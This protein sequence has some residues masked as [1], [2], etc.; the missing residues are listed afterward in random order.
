M[1]TNFDKTRQEIF[2]TEKVEYIDVNYFILYKPERGNILPIAL[3][4]SDNF[5]QYSN[6]DFIYAKHD[7]YKTKQDFI[8]ELTVIRDKMITNRNN[9]IIIDEPCAL[10]ITSY[11]TGTGHGYSELYAILM[12]YLKIHPNKE[13]KIAIYEKSQ[14]GILEI[15]KHFFKQEDIIILKP[16]EFYKFKTL[17][18]IPYDYCSFLVPFSVKLDKELISKYIIDKNFSKYNYEKVA[19]IKTE[20]DV[21]ISKGRNFNYENVLKYCNDNNIYL[22][23][24]KKNTEIEIANIIFKA[25]YLILSWGTNFYKHYPYIS[26]NCEIIDNWILDNSGYKDEY[27]HFYAARHMTSYKNC[28][29]N[30]FLCSS[31]ISYIKEL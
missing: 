30:K 20:N 6:D 19:V 16:N 9:S 31:D 22:I 28:K 21:A 26:D 25:K 5:I 1:F 3:D 10:F 15:I 17:E 4:N 18:I 29:I 27:E 23:D 24:C 11:S 12:K 14:K 2:D 8:S 7:Y 13:L